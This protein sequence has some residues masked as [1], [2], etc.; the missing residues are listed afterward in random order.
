MNKIDAPKPEEFSKGRCPFCGI[1]IKNNLG[2]HIRETHGEKQFKQA[3]LMAKSSGMSD[4]EIGAHFGISFRQLEQIITEAYGA[5]ISV[6][7]RPKKIRTWSPKNFQEETTTVWSFKQRGNWATHDGR[8]RGNWSPYIPRNVIIK[9][10]KP[11]E[12][13][14]DYFV[15]GG[16]TAIEAKLL[17][18]RCI[19]RDINP[20]AI[21]LT[22]ENLRF[23]LPQCKLNEQIY[24]PKVS[25]GDARNLIDIDDSTIDLICAHPP[26]AG[27]INYSSAVEGDLSK[28][29][30]EEFLTEMSKVAR[31]SFRVLKP[32]GKC[33]ILIGDARKAKH[34]IPIGFQTIR[35]FL[36]TGFVLRELVIKRQH[37]CKT[38]GFWYN[39][40]IQHNFLLLAH[41]YLPIFEKPGANHRLLEE[42]VWEHKHISEKGVFW[43]YK[44]PYQAISERIKK[45][46]KEKLETTTVWIFPEKKLNS[47][48]KRNLLN[49]F[50]ERK[51]RFIEVKFE[52]N[53]VKLSTTTK[54]KL[55]LVYIAPPE[56][57]NDHKE[58]TAY[59]KA[60]QEIAEQVI[61]LLST[62]GFFVVDTKDVRVNGVLQPM[63]LLL[64]EDLS[65]Y[66]D[67]IIKEIVIV[68]PEE[69]PLKT[70]NEFL[71][72]VHR[73]L[74]I[75]RKK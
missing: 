7:G 52:D 34:V 37:N 4:P 69:L 49:R 22:R 53:I 39:R 11:G 59:R 74:L 61:S 27:I 45:I 14:L 1:E 44:L 12:V 40:S 24:E 17:G 3:V 25:E 31:E 16:T 35:V 10:S 71:Q 42:T 28:L 2:H 43:E 46:K 36:N 47:E 19:A 62:N 60:V 51:S 63:A 15:G 18:R 54:N 73:Y 58:V 50:L 32:N 72:I 6:L 75:F 8:Y 9:Y 21:K 57:L 33:A 26:Y 65:K 23:T 13:V 55:S 41:E 29:S 64:W 48:I 30:V 20:E 70:F 38:T 67:F 68:V 66:N 5:N 56:K